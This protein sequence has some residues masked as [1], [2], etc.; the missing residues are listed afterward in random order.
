LRSTDNLIYENVIFDSIL[1]EKLSE[2]LYRRGLQSVIIEGG[3]KT[4]QTFIQAG[5]WD[6]A[7]VFTGNVFLENGVH[8]PIL[9]GT[10]VSNTIKNDRLSIFLNHD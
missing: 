7:R 4:L 3:T 2:V 8:A 10:G 1:P 9:H 6:E 5:H